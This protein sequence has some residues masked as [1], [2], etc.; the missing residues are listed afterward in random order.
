MD[1]IDQEKFQEITAFNQED[2]T[3][4]G[5]RMV[6]NRE[7]KSKY[8]DVMEEHLLRYEWAGQY[9][10]GKRVLDAA[11]GS[12]YGCKMLKDAGASAVVGVDIST[13]AIEKA[14]P[15]YG[16]DGITFVH[17]DILK[18]PF[19]D[20]SFD[21]VVSFETIEHV[22]EGSLWIEESARV[23][24]ANGLLLLS[25]PNRRIT[26]PGIFREEKGMNPYHEFEYTVEEF[27]G[28]LCEQYAVMELLGQSFVHDIQNY[29]FQIARL[30][31]GRIHI[32]PTPWSNPGKR[33]TALGKCKNMQPGYLIAVCQKKND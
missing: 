24:K 2:V 9:V 5:E 29:F 13:E 6:I 28:D 30:S 33:I 18:L 14:K 27:I 11:C 32:P 26:H 20:E 31:Q 25:T 19:P 21:L 8:S 4:T 15:A 7:V 3:F 10:K 16:D 12:G 23:L 1:N 22:K 17:G